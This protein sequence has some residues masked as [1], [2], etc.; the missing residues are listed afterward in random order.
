MSLFVF[1]S[2]CA[3][4][5]TL[6]SIFPTPRRMKT[7]DLPNRQVISVRQRTPVFIR[8]KQGFF[9]RLSHG[10]NVFPWLLLIQS[11]KK[12]LREFCQ[13][14]RASNCR[15]TGHRTP[16]RILGTVRRLPVSI[17]TGCTGKYAAAPAFCCRSSGRT[18]RYSPCRTRRSRKHPLRLTL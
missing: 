11:F 6:S 7:D 18:F 13:I 17:R 3:T 9:D 14:G 2:F 12:S 5:C 15:K 16:D 10:N 8:R 4:Y 1:Y